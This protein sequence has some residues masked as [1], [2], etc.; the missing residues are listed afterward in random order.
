MPELRDDLARCNAGDDDAEGERHHRQAGIR[1]RD[2]RNV[3]EIQREKDNPE[4]KRGTDHEQRR[5]AEADDPIT[6]QLEV[7]DGVRCV[8]LANEK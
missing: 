7:Q 3:D 6:E 8:P 4:E 5:G 1:S 2:S